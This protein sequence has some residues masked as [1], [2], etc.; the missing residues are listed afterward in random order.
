MQL[1]TLSGDVMLQKA[2][3]VHQ[4]SQPGASTASN[5]LI[6]TALAFPVVLMSFSDTGMFFSVVGAL[7]SAARGFKRGV[8]SIK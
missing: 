4:S 7:V 2:L 1:L 8:G 3:N 6:L 5:V